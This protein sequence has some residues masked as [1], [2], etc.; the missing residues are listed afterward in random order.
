LGTQQPSLTSCRF[1]LIPGIGNTGRSFLATYKHDLSSPPHKS[2]TKNEMLLEAFCVRS[3]PDRVVPLHD[4]YDGLCLQSEN[5]HGEI[6]ICLKGP[7]SRDGG[8]DSG[9]KE[10]E[11]DN[12]RNVA[13]DLRNTHKFLV[14]EYVFDNEKG[15]WKLTHESNTTLEDVIDIM[16]E[17]ILS[18]P[19]LR[20]P[21]KAVLPPP[22]NFI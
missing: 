6:C 10:I 17:Q 4:L 3:I 15:T 14:L 9:T 8:A 11:I 18:R 12:E 19:P 20:K 13:A 21:T 22:P 1:A 7:T 2:L 16:S 5:K